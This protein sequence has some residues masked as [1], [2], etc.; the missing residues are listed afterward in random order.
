MGRV[1]APCPESL[2]RRAPVDGING[3]HLRLGQECCFH[4]IEN[5]GWVVALVVTFEVDALAS[6]HGRG[7]EA[8]LALKGMPTSE[9]VFGDGT[10]AEEGSAVAQDDLRVVRR[11]EA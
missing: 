3:L 4:W 1:A 5:D 7:C 9:A 6:G 2:R 10:C 8:R 11:D